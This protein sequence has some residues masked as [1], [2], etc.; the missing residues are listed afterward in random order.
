MGVFFFSYLTKKSTHLGPATLKKSDSTRSLLQRYCL[1]SSLLGCGLRPSLLVCGLRPAISLGFD[2]LR[3]WND[4]RNRN[5]CVYTA[6]CDY[7]IF[8]SARLFFFVSPVLRDDFVFCYYWF[9]IKKKIE[10]DQ[11]LFLFIYL[12]GIYL[13]RYSFIYS[14][15]C[16]FIHSFYW[17]L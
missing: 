7:L 13:F 4:L 3:N 6:R 14:F 12:F 10:G 2:D 11:N 15:I 8:T 16:L 9:Y 17:R 5:E 1:R